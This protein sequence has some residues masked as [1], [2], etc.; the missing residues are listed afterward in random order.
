MLRPDDADVCN[1]T[2]EDGML[3]GVNELL[4]SAYDDMLSRF[5]HGDNDE[6]MEDLKQM[7][8]RIHDETLRAV[9]NSLYE[10]TGMR[11]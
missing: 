4:I 8:R 3:A 6:T 10:N 1:V 2:R 9:K 5:E 7:A 11:T